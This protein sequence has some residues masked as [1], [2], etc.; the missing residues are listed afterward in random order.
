MDSF[1][2]IQWLHGGKGICQFCGAVSNHRALLIRSYRPGRLFLCRSCAQRVRDD[3]D[4]FLSKAMSVFGLKQ[5]EPSAMR[6]P[7]SR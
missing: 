1:Q 4:G 6:E 7:A 3:V 2:P 5:V